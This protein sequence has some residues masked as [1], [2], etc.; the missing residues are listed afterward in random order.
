M[1]GRLNIV[2][3]P[4]SQL[5]SDF[6]GINFKVLSNTNLCPSETVATVIRPPS[7]FNQVNAQWGL[8]P[9]WTPKLLINAQAESAHQKQTF[10]DAIIHSRC[11]IPITGWYEWKSVEH[12]KLKYEFIHQ[13]NRPLYMGGLLFNPNAPQLVTLTKSPTL[14]CSKIH[15]RMPVL[16]NQEHIKDW[17]DCPTQE[18]SSLYNQQNTEY[19]KIKRCN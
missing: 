9:S 11:L 10:K 6:L 13:D 7:G 12:K 1:C 4:L 2:D 19:I 8:Q 18:L 15:N 3:D 5:V 14:A 16:I 17:F